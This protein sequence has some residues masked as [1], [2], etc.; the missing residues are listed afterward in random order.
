MNSEAKW[1]KFYGA[2]PHTLDYPDISLYKMVENAGE[3][4]PEY[5]AYDFMGKSS[6]Y[7]EFLKDIDTCA[8][9]LIQEGIKKGDAV[10]I[11]LPNVPQAVIKIG[12]AHV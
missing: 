5:I 3:K 7:R 2:T 8:K 10:T 12:R 4:Y 9:A 1:F 6:T 11:C